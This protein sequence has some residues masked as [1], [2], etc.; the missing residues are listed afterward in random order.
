M[1][2]RT[3][4]SIWLILHSSVMRHRGDWFLQGPRDASLVQSTHGYDS[5]LSYGMDYVNG[6]C[7]YGYIIN[8]VP[9]TEGEGEGGDGGTVVCVCVCARVYACVS[10]CVCVLVCVYVPACSACMHGVVQVCLCMLV[11]I[12]EHV[13]VLV[14]VWVCACTS[15]I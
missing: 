5:L 4:L 13:D 7:E 8:C 1:E 6:L 9:K 11:H 10:A 15:M 12:L 14:C 3:A 2:A